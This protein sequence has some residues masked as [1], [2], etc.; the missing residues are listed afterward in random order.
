MSQVNSNLVKTNTFTGK[1]TAGSIVVTS[2]GGATTTNLQ[3]G[4]AKAWANA[5]GNATSINDSFNTTSLTDT[6]TGNA[7]FNLT[8]N[9]SATNYSFTVGHQYSTTSGTG[10]FFSNPISDSSSA[11]QTQHYQNGS[12]A[13]PQKYSGLAVHGDLA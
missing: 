7:Q 10:A 11:Y 2:E 3:Q 5:P 4:L 6:N 1:T 8:N 9:M 12:I 13:D